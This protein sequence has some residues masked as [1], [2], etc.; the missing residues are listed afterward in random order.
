MCRSHALTAYAPGLGV[1]DAH[2]DWLVDVLLQDLLEE[3]VLLVLEG[4][5]E[6]GARLLN[7]SGR[8]SHAILAKIMQNNAK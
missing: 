2:F 8:T 6:Q 1:V 7:S 5:G 3:V 4:Q